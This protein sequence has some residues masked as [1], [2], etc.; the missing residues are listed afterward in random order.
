M[1]T[2]DKY[3]VFIAVTRINH[4]KMTILF[5]ARLNKNKDI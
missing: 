3:I 2:F 1:Q 4:K 5:C